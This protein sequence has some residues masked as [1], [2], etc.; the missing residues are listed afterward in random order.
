MLTTLYHFSPPRVKLYTDERP[1]PSLQK[2]PLCSY[3]PRRVQAYGHTWV[4][5]QHRQ[6]ET[7]DPYYDLQL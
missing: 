1:I 2:R 6:D 3:S 4:H 7:G 5:T